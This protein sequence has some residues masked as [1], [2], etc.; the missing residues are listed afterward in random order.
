[1]AAYDMGKMIL[2]I[3]SVLWDLAFPRKQPQFYLKTALPLQQWEMR[4]NQLLALDIW[5][6]RPSPYANGLTET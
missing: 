2:F 6:S 1:M 4:E 3:R 5:I